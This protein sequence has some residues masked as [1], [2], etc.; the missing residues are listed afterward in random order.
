MMATKIGQAAGHVS[1]LI[2][3]PTYFVLV[4]T[5]KSKYIDKYHHQSTSSWWYS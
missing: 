4:S 3:T 2:T 5:P 1:L